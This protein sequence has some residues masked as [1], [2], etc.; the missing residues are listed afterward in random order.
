MFKSPKQGSRGFYVS[1][2][3]EKGNLFK[4]SDILL[5][6]TKSQKIMLLYIPWNTF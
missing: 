1:G 4:Y 3:L 6:L 2:K 5:D